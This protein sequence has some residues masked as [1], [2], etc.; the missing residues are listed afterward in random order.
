MMC[1][2]A[3]SAATDGG[4]WGAGASSARAATH[5]RLSTRASAQDFDMPCSTLDPTGALP[6]HVVFRLQLPSLA[7]IA[8]FLGTV[9]ERIR[10]YVDERPACLLG[11]EVMAVEH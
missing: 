10:A 6:R 1:S 7:A 11:A 8:R 9:D 2:A 5:R 3:V 4:A